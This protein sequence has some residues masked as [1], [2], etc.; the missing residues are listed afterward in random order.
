MQQVPWIQISKT[1]GTDAAN[2]DDNIKIRWQMISKSMWG[3]NAC[4]IDEI[5]LCATLFGTLQPTKSPTLQTASPTKTPSVA[6]APP[7][8]SPTEPPIEPCKIG[9]GY[10][11]E[12]LPAGAIGYQHVIT[13]DGDDHH[14]MGVGDESQQ[15]YYIHPCDGTTRRQMPF[16]LLGRHVKYYGSVTTIDYVTLE[17]FDFNGDKYFVW[18]S[19]SINSWIKFES[20]PE[21]STVY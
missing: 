17:L 13:G 11:I 18:L 4:L 6:S 7:S 3:E 14:F 1:L 21:T 12:G 2:T 15:Y 19:S 9:V 16:T 10:S 20:L 5:K 8:K